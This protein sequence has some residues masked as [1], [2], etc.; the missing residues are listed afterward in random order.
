MICCRASVF[1]HRKPVL[2]A[3]PLA[4]CYLGQ[5]QGVRRRELYMSDQ[6]DNKTFFRKDMTL[7][8]LET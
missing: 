2:I 8:L 6:T 4:S 1:A 5:A 7:G 3:N